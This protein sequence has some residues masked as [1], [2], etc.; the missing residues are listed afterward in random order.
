MRPSATPPLLAHAAELRG[1]ALCATGGA[2]AWP[3]SP[4]T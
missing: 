2:D 3:P 1:V 4:G